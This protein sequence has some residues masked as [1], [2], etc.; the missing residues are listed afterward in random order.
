ML[1]VC[2]STTARG[3]EEFKEL[4]RDMVGLT[5]HVYILLTIMIVVTGLKDALDYQSCQYIR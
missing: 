1:L 3:N 4:G 2:G 5:S